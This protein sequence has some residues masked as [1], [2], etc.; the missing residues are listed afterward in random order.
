MLTERQYLYEKSQEETLQIKEKHSLPADYKKQFPWLKEVDSLALANAQLSLDS[1]YK[2]FF[3]DKIFGF[4][5]FKSKHHDEM[6]YTTNNQKGS[7]RLLDTKT[8]RLPKLKDIKIKL[9]R[10]LPETALIKAATI[11]KTPTGKYYIA[12]RLDFPDIENIQKQIQTIESNINYPDYCQKTKD[13]LKKA[14][15]HLARCKKDSNNREKAKR[16]LALLHEKDANQRKDFLHKLS[17]QIA[18]AVNERKAETI[19]S[20]A[21]LERKDKNNHSGLGMLNRFIA[22]KLAG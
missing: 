2:N 4:P 15:K 1:A 20:M 21:Q 7:I 19:Q 22:Y 6:S 16:K 3:R 11:S 17:R 13:K 18:N 12:I 8:L 9:H 14:Q 5:R 10:Q